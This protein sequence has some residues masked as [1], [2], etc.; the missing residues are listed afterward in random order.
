MQQNS[1]VKV[2]WIY[3]KMPSSSDRRRKI[4]FISLIS[5]CFLN[6]DIWISQPKNLPAKKQGQAGKWYVTP[7]FEV[8]TP[9]TTVKNEI[10]NPFQWQTLNAR[11]VR[12]TLSSNVQQFCKPK[13]SFFMR[14]KAVKRISFFLEIWCCMRSI[15]HVPYRGE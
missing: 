2:I 7:A 3:Y 5:K 10:W 12:T 14:E 1:K 8:Y 4:L 6:E 15:H 11:P 13:S 9:H